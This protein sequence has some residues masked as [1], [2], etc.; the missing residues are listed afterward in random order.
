MSDSGAFVERENTLVVDCLFFEDK[1]L[2]D[3]KRNADVYDDVVKWLKVGLHF[4]SKHYM[5][6]AF[7]H[8][9]IWFVTIRQLY[10]LKSF[11]FLHSFMFTC[12]CMHIS[13]SITFFL[14]VLTFKNSNFI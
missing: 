10:S 8:N 13:V 11:H 3:C 9:L 4:I 1:G 6:I 2:L 5:N 14:R 7:F 12:G